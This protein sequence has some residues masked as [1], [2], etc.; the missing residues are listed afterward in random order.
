[1]TPAAV[2]CPTPWDLGLEVASWEM[3]SR[4]LAFHRTSRWFKARSRGGHEEK[5]AL[6]LRQHLPEVP[7]LTKECP[8]KQDAAPKPSVITG[9][10]P[11]ATHLGR[12]AKGQRDGVEHGLG[13]WGRVRPCTCG[14]VNGLQF[15]P[16][17]RL[18]AAKPQITVRSSCVVRPQPHGKTNA[19]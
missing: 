16:T 2:A 4:N 6:P 1:M 7:K 15:G 14:K 18:K 9:A 19:G 17:G 11:P 13:M 10:A 5:M 12:S 8:A 3:A